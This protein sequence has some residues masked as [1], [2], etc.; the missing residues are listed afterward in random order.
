MAYALDVRRRAAMNPCQ[1]KAQL[2][3]HRVRRSNDT[4]IRE[5]FADLTGACQF[6]SIKLA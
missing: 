3:L 6:L 5:R 4:N 1:T 2:Q